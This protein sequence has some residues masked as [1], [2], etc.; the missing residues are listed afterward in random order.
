MGIKRPVCF[1]NHKPADPN[2]GRL[3]KNKVGDK[4]S[5]EAKDGEYVAF[6]LFMENEND[7]E[8]IPHEY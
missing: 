2:T 8:I 4:H 6:A 1:G 5:R 3:T 7:I